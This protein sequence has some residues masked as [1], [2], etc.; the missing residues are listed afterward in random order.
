MAPF[1]PWKMQIGLRETELYDL[2]YKLAH[3][4]AWQLPHNAKRCNNANL[5][6]DSL[7][8]TMKGKP[9]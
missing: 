1:I 4:S 7:K 5:L 9:S 2:L 8:S 3:C 6:Q